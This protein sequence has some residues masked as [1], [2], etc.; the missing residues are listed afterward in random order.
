MGDYGFEMIQGITNAEERNGMFRLLGEMYAHQNAP[1]P[2]QNVAVLN[3]RDQ[4]SILLHYYSAA[5]SR[6]LN[7]ALNEVGRMKAGPNRDM[8][9]ES[10][11]LPQI[12]RN[13]KSRALEWIEAIS[14]ENTKQ[15]L[16]K[17]FSDKIQ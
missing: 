6:D 17:E 13:D 11:L 16:Y 8:L 10:V 2:P 9:L 5:A 4:E 7:S 14:S 12:F 1:L 15:R 3:E